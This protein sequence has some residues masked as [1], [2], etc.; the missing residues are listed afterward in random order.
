[1]QKGGGQFMWW[2]YMPFFFFVHVDIAVDKEY[3]L[4]IMLTGIP[5]TI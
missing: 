2:Y 1:M 3:K 5:H 4:I